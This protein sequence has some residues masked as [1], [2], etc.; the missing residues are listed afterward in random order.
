[1]ARM[2]KPITAPDRDANA[3][4]AKPAYQRARGRASV[5][6]AL[7]DG[8]TRLSQLAQM[9]AAKAMLPRVHSADPELV[10]LNTAG[11]LTA[12]DRLEY[13]ITLGAGTRASAVTQTAERAYRS[14]PDLPPARLD[15]SITVGAGGHLS[16]LPQETILFDH[17]S[18]DR[19]TQINLAE[20]A[21][22]LACETVVLGRAAMGETVSDL[23]FRDWREIR[24]AGKP[25]YLDPLTLSGRD[26]D[27]AA[28][29]AVLGGARAMSS[30]IY[31]APEAEDRLDPLRQ[32]LESA[33]AD[34]EVA[35]SAWDG[36]LV[37]RAM[38]GDAAPL[39][40]MLGA[41]IQ[42]LSGAALPRVWQM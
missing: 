27:L 23:S 41:A 2:N 33:G 19:R 29:P 28:H 1:M 14:L 7:K 26:L 31:C 12:G 38:A 6:F 22:C 37:L 25:I 9:G 42:Y 30:L 15:V 10:F 11:G 40:H 8:R 4:S 5:G 3:V 16:W 20:D 39:R 24:R 18:L 13:E 21:S 36:R 32:L 34:I 17:A 35:A